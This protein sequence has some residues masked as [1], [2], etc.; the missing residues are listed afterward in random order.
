M[1]F[2]L[3]IYRNCHFGSILSVDFG[4]IFVSKFKF[5]MFCDKL[6]IFYFADQLKRNRLIKSYFFTEKCL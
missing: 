5:V 6:S 3:I 2:N 4:V 1:T